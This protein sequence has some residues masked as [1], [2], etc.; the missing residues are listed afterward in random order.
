ML[1]PEQFQGKT[2]SI[3]TS[4]SGAEL[5]LTGLSAVIESEK[6]STLEAVS[7]KHFV[8]ICRAQSD[9]WRSFRVYPVP[10]SIA[11]E[12]GERYF[13]AK[14]A[15]LASLLI[16][17]APPAMVRDRFLDRQDQLRWAAFL[18]ELYALL[19]ESGWSVPEPYLPEFAD[20][21][22]A[23]QFSLYRLYCRR[24]DLKRRRDLQAESEIL[25]EI[26]RLENQLSSASWTL[27]FDRAEVLAKLSRVSE[28]VSVLREGAKTTEASDEKT[29]LLEYAVALETGRH[30]TR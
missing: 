10:E 25:E 9:G 20:E 11:G 27:F 30:P 6:P 13:A 5:L 23:K 12:K 4:N 1:M 8:Q 22:D 2:R 16:A 14:V 21:M 24:V 26:I 29:T 15:E 3:H 19:S 7:V 18:A 17:G 28:A